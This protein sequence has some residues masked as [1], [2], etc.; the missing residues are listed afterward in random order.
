MISTILIV[1]T[2]VMLVMECADAPGNRRGGDKRTRALHGKRGE[3]K[4]QKGAQEDTKVTVVRRTERNGGRGVWVGGKMQAMREE[5]SLKN[6]GERK[7]QMRK[8]EGGKKNELRWCVELAKHSYQHIF[9]LR[10][11]CP[12]YKH[13]LAPCGSSNL[14]AKRDCVMIVSSVMR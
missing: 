7:K 9:V 3:D 12:L 1:V 13:P 11:I 5:S 2:A 6:G 14:P 10:L 8:E 4:M